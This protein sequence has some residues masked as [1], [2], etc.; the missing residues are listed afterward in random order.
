MSSNNYARLPGSSVGHVFWVKLHTT[1]RSCCPMVSSN[2]GSTLWVVKLQCH[3]VHTI[4]LNQFP[5]PIVHAAL[6]FF[7]CFFGFLYNNGLWIQPCYSI[8]FFAWVLTL[9]PH[10]LNL[11]CWELDP[12]HSLLDELDWICITVLPV[13][14]RKIPFLFRSAGTIYLSCLYIFQGLC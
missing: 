2:T 13:Q 5:C 8:G 9:H 1:A 6:L 3:K 10:C 4:A 11:T 14:K 7:C 12:N